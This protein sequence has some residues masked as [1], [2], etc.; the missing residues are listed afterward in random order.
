MP[1]LNIEQLAAKIMADHSLPERGFINNSDKTVNYELGKDISVFK[2]T[3][4]ND[5]DA[6][7]SYSQVI[8]DLSEVLNL[9][10]YITKPKEERIAFLF[11]IPV[12]TLT[13]DLY[14]DKFYTWAKLEMSHGKLYMSLSHA[15]NSVFYRQYGINQDYNRAMTSMHV[16]SSLAKLQHMQMSNSK[17]SENELLIK[18]LDLFT[19]YYKP[20]TDTEFDIRN[21]NTH[22]YT[23]GFCSNCPAISDFHMQILD[24]ND[25]FKPI[26]NITPGMVCVKTIL[27]DVYK[28]GTEELIEHAHLTVFE[29]QTVGDDSTDLS[30]VKTN[31]ESN[32]SYLDPKHQK[33]YARLVNVF[34]QEKAR[35]NKA[36]NSFIKDIDELDD[37]MLNDYIKL[38]TSKE[39]TNEDKDMFKLIHLTMTE[40]LDPVLMKKVVDYMTDKTIDAYLP[41]VSKL[42]AYMRMVVLIANHHFMRSY[43]Q[44]AHMCLEICDAWIYD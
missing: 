37:K 38:F 17:K 11:I 25:V 14:D 10:D 4:V 27:F 3:M 19:D 24:I 5:S 32:S 1:N 28:P 16:L 22:L 31:I 9:G 36:I 34:N 29:A 2:V 40:K 44:N 26:K 7:K 18:T 21:V 42:A 33:F 12:F 39:L 41:G 23:G 8:G 35:R 20:V 30:M 6:V 15:L 13:Y 43:R